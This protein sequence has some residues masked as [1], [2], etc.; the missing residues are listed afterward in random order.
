MYIATENIILDDRGFPHLTDFGIAYTKDESDMSNNILSCNLASG[1]KQYLAPE[2]FTKSHLHG[3]ECDYWSL[4][5][6]VYELLL[7]KRP[8]DRHCPTA[9][10]HY[11]ELAFRQRQ[12][13]TPGIR[14]IKCNSLSSLIDNQKSPGICKKAISAFAESS[15]LKSLFSP[16]GIT[17][18]SK[19]GITFCGS[20]LSSGSSSSSSSMNGNHSESSCLDSYGERDDSMTSNPFHQLP[21]L[22]RSDGPSRLFSRNKS[23]GS[24]DTTREINCTEDCCMLSNSSSNLAT[25]ST[26][27]STSSSISYSSYHVGDYWTYDS[28]KL[29]ENLHV[30]IPAFSLWLGPLSVSLVSLLQGLFDPRPSHRLGCRNILFL[31][32]HPWFREHGVLEWDKVERRQLLPTF[33]PNGSHLRETSSNVD[34]MEVINGSDDQYHHLYLPAISEEEEKVFAG[35]EYISSDMASLT[36][37]FKKVDMLGSSNHKDTMEYLCA[38][39]NGANPTFLS[40]SPSPSLGV[41][42][43]SSLS[44]K[45]PLPS[46]KLD[47]NFCIRR[48][49]SSRTKQ[50]QSSL[51]RQ[52]AL[53]NVNSAVSSYLAPSPIPS[54]GP[55]LIQSIPEKGNY[56]LGQESSHQNSNNNIL[57]NEVSSRNSS[58]IYSGGDKSRKKRVIR[59][60][61]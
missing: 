48:T 35:F 23:R 45:E 27:S 20:P 59:L 13:R 4:G 40:P 61:R 52:D 29:P 39:G 60:H 2:V 6:V 38:D 22:I 58:S 54:S 16:R 21:R 3:P 10:I 28:D 49:S 33:M 9:M 47:R 42:Y 46:Y 51:I 31:V 25:T 56:L 44:S 36:Q 18:S 30:N 53:P 32:N 37:V 41:V 50:E 8:F 57:P 55:S 7:G 12:Q 1:T 24:E 14:T 34:I 26:A 11:L 5:I 15:G 43:D 17:R 19:N